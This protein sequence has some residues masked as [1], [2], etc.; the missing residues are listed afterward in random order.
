MSGVLWNAPGRSIASGS[1]L[2]VQDLGGQTL[3]AADGHGVD[4]IGASQY[5]QLSTAGGLKYE[6]TDHLRDVAASEAYD[7]AT[8]TITTTAFRGKVPFF[9]GSA[10][11]E[12]NGVTP[13]TATYSCRS[14]NRTKTQTQVEYPSGVWTNGADPLTAHL[15]FS[16]PFS[17]PDSASGGNLYVFSF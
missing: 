7:S 3:R 14:G 8:Q 12:A 17:I 4:L 1:N 13:F 6:R 16:G 11:M 2:A 15:P 9:T 5:N 10:S